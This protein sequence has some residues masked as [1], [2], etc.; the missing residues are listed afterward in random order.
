MKNIITKAM[1]TVR[2]AN[3]KVAKAAATVA[4]AAAGAVVSVKA[5][6]YGLTLS[7]ASAAKFNSGTEWKASGSDPTGLNNIIT[8]IIAGIGSVGIIFII[9]GGVSIATAI[10]SGEQNPDAITGAIKN[11]LVGGLLLGLGFIVGNLAG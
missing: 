2:K 10:K 6:Y 5:A 8:Y 4:V 11:I 7:Y 9:I 3:E 1:Q